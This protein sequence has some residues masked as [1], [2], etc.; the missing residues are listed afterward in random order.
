MLLQSPSSTRLKRPSWRLALSLTKEALRACSHLGWVGWGVSPMQGP[1]EDGYTPDVN[2]RP[3]RP[4][5]TFQGPSVSFPRPTDVVFRGGIVDTREVPVPNL[6]LFR[7]GFPIRDGSS[8][9]TP[10]GEWRCDV[11][12]PDRPVVRW[13]PSLLFRPSRPVD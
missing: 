10:T 5:Q 11:M 12:A 8:N 4:G 2:S 7:R 1:D 6:P 3:R 13:F 9:R